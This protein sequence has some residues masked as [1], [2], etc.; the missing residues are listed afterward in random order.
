MLALLKF[1]THMA[2]IL[3]VYGCYAT[4]FETAETAKKVNSKL[5]GG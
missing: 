3:F 2:F 1:F 4:F 5:Q